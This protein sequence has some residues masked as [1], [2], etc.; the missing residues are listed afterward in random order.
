MLSAIFV[1][2]PR[3][4]IV[5]AARA[6]HVNHLVYA[7]D[8]RLDDLRDGRFHDGRIGAGISRGDRHLWR[9]NIGILRERQSI[10]R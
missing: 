3:L 10:E 9:H 2:R 7:D 8:L 1:D 5:I 6:F 4:A